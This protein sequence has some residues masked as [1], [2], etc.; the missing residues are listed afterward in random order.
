MNNLVIRQ[1]R[2][3]KA[4]G[5]NEFPKYLKKKHLG[6]VS[7]TPEVADVYMAILLANATAG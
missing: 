2:K 3:T 6:L 1:R 5:P 4:R 7:K